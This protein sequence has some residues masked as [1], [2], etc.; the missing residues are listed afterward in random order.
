MANRLFDYHMQQIA[1]ALKDSQF[2]RIDLNS[3][4]DESNAFDFVIQVWSENGVRV[5]QSREHRLLPNQAVMGYSTAMM[6]NGEWIIYAIH[7]QQSYT[8]SSIGSS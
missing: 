2:D 7:T 4:V 6:D 8:S 1:L 3:K 5:Y